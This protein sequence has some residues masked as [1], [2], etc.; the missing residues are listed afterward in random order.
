L[1]KKAKYDTSAE[2]ASVFVV[3]HF[4]DLFKGSRVDAIA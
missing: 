4:E 1:G 3:I 2:F